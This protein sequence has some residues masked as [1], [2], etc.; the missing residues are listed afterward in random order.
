MSRCS[1]GGGYTSNRYNRREDDRLKN[2]P[3]RLRNKRNEEL[4]HVPMA[5]TT[6]NSD[7]VKEVGG[8]GGG[9][10]YS[11]KDTRRPHQSQVVTCTDTINMHLPCPHFVC[12]KQQIVLSRSSILL[13]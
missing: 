12:R 4:G 7:V 2:L 10:E 8:A 3:N 1:G 5:T 9:S 6:N 13:L 11:K